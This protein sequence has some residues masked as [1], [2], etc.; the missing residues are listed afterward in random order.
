LNSSASV[1]ISQWAYSVTR[2]QHNNATLGVGEDKMLLNL[3]KGS[4]VTVEL[5]KQE[6][7]LQCRSGRIWVTVSGDP[8]DYLLE[9]TE[10]RLIAGPGRVVIEVLSGSCFGMHSEADLSVKVNEDYC[11]PDAIDSSGR[12][13]ERKPRS[14]WRHPQS[15][16]PVFRIQSKITSG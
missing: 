9:G 14:F 3:E 2:I 16:L 4:L 15:K 11:S 5:G 13:H 12:A 10:E 1:I 8:R 6:C 7:V